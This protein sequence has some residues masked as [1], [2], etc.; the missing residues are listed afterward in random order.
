MSMEDNIISRTKSNK[1]S[2]N[3]KGVDV[4]VYDILNA[5]DVQNPALQHLIKKALMPG[6]RGHKDREQDMKEIVASA[7]RAAELE[8]F[9]GE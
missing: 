4:D 9:D 8:G 2:K 6:E 3:I 1:Y 5:F 7:K